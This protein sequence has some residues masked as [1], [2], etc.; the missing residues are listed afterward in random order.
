[1]VQ[2]K[3]LFDVVYSVK[4]GILWSSIALHSSIHCAFCNIWHCIAWFGGRDLV[5]V[6]IRA[7]GHITGDPSN[8]SGAVVRFPNPPTCFWKQAKRPTAKK[9]P[10]NTVTQEHQGLLKQGLSQ[11]VVNRSGQAAFRLPVWYSLP[12]DHISIFIHRVQ[13]P[14][15][16][17]TGARNVRWN[18]KPAMWNDLLSFYCA[19]SATVSTEDCLCIM[20][21][22]AQPAYNWYAAW[23]MRHKQCIAIVRPY[24]L[25]QLTTIAMMF[26]WRVHLRAQAVPP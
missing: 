3:F 4:Y 9:C 16:I 25:L 19:A 26:T 17:C 7:P 1:M 24:D 15:M 20:V 8:A 12:S 11:H 22:P 18:P 14:C 2:S 6:R 23:E 5:R 13:K 10:K 21:W